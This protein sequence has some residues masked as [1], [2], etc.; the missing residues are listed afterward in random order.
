MQS[1]W[2]LQFIKAGGFI[3]MVAHLGVAT[4]YPSTPDNLFAIGFSLLLFSIALFWWS[5]STFEEQPPAVAFS[6]KVVT[7][8]NTR[9][10]YRFIR[11]PLYSSY[12]LAWL[13]GTLATGCWWLL[14][15]F[16]AMGYVYVVAA[17]EEKK[18]W[19]T[20]DNEAAYKKYKASTRGFIPDILT[21]LK[22]RKAN[23][24]ESI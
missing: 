3:F 15:S 13:G 1:T 7:S 21:L 4:L 11:H 14:I 2:E 18:Q 19:L 12:M 22:M 5:V 10:P 20:G 16:F 23:S 9:G 8:L 24:D 17:R 6:A